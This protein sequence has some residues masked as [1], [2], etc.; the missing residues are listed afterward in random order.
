MLSKR[1]LRALLPLLCA[2]PPSL[3]GCGGGEPPD[4]GNA[5]FAVRE[6]VGQL[7]VTHARP[8]HALTVLDAQRKEV[9]SGTVDA[10][11]SL[12][13]RKLAPGTGYVVRDAQAAPVEERRSLTVLSA[14]ASRPPPSAYA[15]QKLAAGFQYL[16]MRDGT[17]LSAYVTLPGPLEKGPFPT[18]VDYS[19]YAPS[20][21]GEPLAGNQYASLCPSL[22]ILCDAPNDPSAL[23]A[24]VLGY[25]TVSVN[26]RG[27]GC[28][29]GAYDYFETLQRLDGYDVIEIVAAQEWVLHNRVGMVGLSY[30]GITQLFVARERPPGLAAITPLSVI[31]GTSSTLVPGGILN[32]GFAISWVTHVLDKAAPYGQGWEQARVDAGDTECAEN[33]LLHG[34]R[35]DNVQQAVDTPF[36]VP[37]VVGPLDPVRF[38]GAISVPVFLAG[39]FQDEQTGPFSPLLFDKFAGA[40]LARFTAYNG[41]HVDAFAPAVLS[42]W[43][44]FLDL[45]VAGRVPATTASARFLA[46]AVFEEVFGARLEWPPDRFAGKTFA[47]ALAAFEA[48]PPVRVL[49]ENGAGKA[50]DPGAPVPA[51]EQSFSRW[52]PEQAAPLRLFLQPGGALA[53]AAPAAATAASSFLLDPAAGARGILAGGSVWDKQPHYSWRQPDAGSAVVFVGPP[54]AATLVMAGTGS[55]DLWLRATVDDA[56]LEVN[57]SEVRPDGQEQFVQSGW[58]RAS[59]RKLAPAESTALWPEQTHLEADVAPLVPGQWVEARVALA[60]FAHAF[61]AGSRLRLSV[62]T[63]GDSRAEWRFRLKSFAGPARTDVGHDAAH[64]SSVALPV[65][66]GV[67]A[68]TPLAPCASLRGQQCRA[69][70]PYANVPAPP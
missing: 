57:L 40:P 55:V 67:A 38:V 54:L 68:P 24:G 20:K 14:E 26:V 58:L 22:P 37:E 60:P 65:L 64:P 17:T 43:K 6:S 3:A 49:F 7:H 9:A 30:P 69:F 11:G 61:R 1:L 27:T 70:V 31:A 18:V 46:P 12:V 50:D 59:Q 29:G 41:V 47:Q 4:L 8:G 28:S 48:E 23:I 19:G 51:F 34:Q 13:L 10:L 39:A 63:P 36:Y 44:E 15:K 42:R 32:D 33:Q 45:Y 2:L 35:V 21:P 5:T 62:D 56:D 66:A 52:P 53:E 25:A 16:T